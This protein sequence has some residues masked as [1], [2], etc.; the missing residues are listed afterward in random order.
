MKLKAKL[1]GMKRLLRPFWRACEASRTKA[2]RKGRRI[3][4]AV[5]EAFPVRLCAC[6]C[7]VVLLQPIS[8][9]W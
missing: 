7:L 1:I 5:L 2:Q 9:R 8:R 6:T 4:L 3:V